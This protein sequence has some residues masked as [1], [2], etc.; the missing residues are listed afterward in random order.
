LTTPVGGTGRA[1]ADRLAAE[2]TGK[3]WAERFN[4]KFEA[5]DMSESEA[6]LREQL[7]TR[8]V[9]EMVIRVGIVLLLAFWSFQIFKP[10]LGPVVWGII[11]SIASYGAFSWLKDLLGGR[12]GLAATLFALLALAILITPT[13][14]LSDSLLSSAQGLEQQ[15]ETGALQI[16]EPPERVAKLPIVGKRLYDTWALASSNLADALADFQPQIN[17]F[18]RWLLKKAVGTGLDILLFA[19]SIII[20]AI[21]LANA[22]SAGRV[23]REIFVRLADERGEQF[24][25]LTRDT[26]TSV[27]RGVLGIAVLQTL[28]L[29]V[30]LIVAGVPAAGVLSVIT[31]LFAVAQI[32]M[33]VLFLPIIGFVFATADTG[34]AVPFAI[35]SV[36]FSFADG[37]LKPLLL[38]RGLAVPMPVILIGV[39]GGMIA[40]GIIGL[41][42]GPIVLSF[43][44]VLFTVWL[45]QKAP[46]PGE[47]SSA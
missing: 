40:N 20:A 30:G 26:V 32:P 47:K 24:V 28:F 10:F 29:A 15:L 39:I 25:R 27:A 44:Y 3:V 5:T 13:V 33:L 35:W 36:F 11:I 46:P 43:G 34:V 38:G 14:I 37:F 4:W 2:I 19:L 41:F 1:S 22:E 23:G 42:V 45:G 9:M 16:P 8:K 18:S 7:Y 21:F 17:T 12:D 6:Q 31:L